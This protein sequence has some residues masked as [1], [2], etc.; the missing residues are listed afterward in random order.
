MNVIAGVLPPSAYPQSLSKACTATNAHTR[1]FSIQSSPLR[2]SGW[3]ILTAARRGLDNKRPT[4]ARDHT[5][6]IP[7]E[8]RDDLRNV[9][10]HVRL[11]LAMRLMMRAHPLSPVC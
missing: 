5:N 4:V 2:Q 3:V 7:T 9:F 11:S 6:S 10:E 1:P 8:D